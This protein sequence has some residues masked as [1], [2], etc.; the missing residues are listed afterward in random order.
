MILAI[1]RSSL[2]NDQVSLFPVKPFNFYDNEVFRI[3]ALFQL[4][5]PAVLGAMGLAFPLSLLFFMDQNITAALVNTPAN[6]YVDHSNI[7]KKQDP[8]YN[9]HT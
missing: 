6:K 7:Y 8:A 1:P 9:L 2:S 4:P 5:W 3:P